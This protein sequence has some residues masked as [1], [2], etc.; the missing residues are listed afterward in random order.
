[1]LALVPL[2]LIAMPKSAGGMGVD[3]S[4]RAQRFAANLPPLTPSQNHRGVRIYLLRHGMTDWNRRGLVQGAGHD[5]PLNEDGR[6]QAIYAAEELAAV[7]ITV[8]ASS[9]L[10]RASET[11]D[12]V[13]AVHPAAARL[14]NEGFGECNYGDLEGKCLHDGSE[15]ARRLL[16]QFDQVS[17]DME[18]DVNAGYPGGETAQQVA[19]RAKRA[20]W[21]LLDD[22]PEDRHICIVGH[23][24]INRL[25]LA[26]LLYGDATRFAPIE[27][28]NTA[29]SVFDY[30]PGKDGWSE[31]V[32]NYCSHT[33]DRG[34]ASGG[35]Y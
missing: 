3:V 28:G 6:A 19:T 33:E 26:N 23:G 34:A 5:I 15:E 18:G 22:C 14:V 21:K 13:H 17:L 9:H 2:L 1:L 25:L 24:R 30:D 27:Q 4:E 12:A 7:P 32:L 35:C 11:A 8:V 10:S 20:L 16:D 31:V 29:I